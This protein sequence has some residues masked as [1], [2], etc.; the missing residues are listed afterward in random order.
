MKHNFMG[1]FVLGVCLATSAAAQEHRQLKAHEHGHG[2]LNIAVEG[3]RVAMEL[4]VPGQDIVGFEHQPQTKKE[5]A[6][7]EKAEGLLKRGLTLFKI[8]AAAQCKLVEANS[9]TE[10][11]DHHHHDDHDHEDASEHSND[12]DSH[13]AEDASGSE[14]SEAQATHNEYNVTY[15]LNCTKPAAM[16]MI[17]FD[18]F[19]SF[20]GAEALT[21]NV[22]TEAS[23][24]TYKA[25]RAKPVIDLGGTM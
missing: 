15:L 11:E 21:V 9:H 1:P 4:N 19:K 8:P 7:A 20:P 5:K 6:A 17:A 18:Y 13:H 23:Q 24:R 22:V 25:T 12:H 14:K 3:S 2:T 10:G 16:T